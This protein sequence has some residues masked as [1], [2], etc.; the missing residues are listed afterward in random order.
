MHCGIYTIFEEGFLLFG[1]LSAKI[2]KLPVS[3]G[4][5]DKYLKD[6]KDSF[7]VK[8]FVGVFN[9]RIL[10]SMSKLRCSTHQESRAE[11]QQRRGGQEIC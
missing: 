8:A 6:P 7:T 9:R 5:E 10:V 1:M 2:F 3:E 11:K 4:F